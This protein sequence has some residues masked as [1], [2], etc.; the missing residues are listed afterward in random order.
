MTLD[1]WRYSSTLLFFPYYS[2][3][4][5]RNLS[6]LDFAKAFDCVNHNILLDKLEHYGVRGNAH[7]LIK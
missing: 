3:L 2:T 4:L 5:F 1:I 7:S 6:F